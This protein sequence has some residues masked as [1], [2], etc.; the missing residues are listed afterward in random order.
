M[1]PLRIL[2]SGGG[3]AGPA[4]AFW[5]ARL[6][7]ACTVLERFPQL[8]ASGQ[9]I[10]IREQG[11]DTARRMGLLETIRSHA[12]DEEGLQFVDDRGW[13][14]ALFPRTEAG[15]GNQG[16]SSEFEIMRGDL[17]RVLAGAAPAANKPDYRFG[18]SVDGFDNE[19]G[20]VRVKLSDGSVERYDMLVGADGQGSRIRKMMLK[21]GDGGKDLSR[22]LG[23]YVAYYSLPRTPQDPSLGT[24]YHA[25]GRRLLATRWH[26]PQRGQGYL[27]TMAHGE[28]MERALKQDVGTQKDVFARVFGDAGWQAAR[29]V[30]EM[31]RADDFYAQTIVQIKCRPW[32]RGRVVLLGDAGYCPSPLTGMGTSAALIGAYV[33]AGELSKRGISSSSPSGQGQE[34]AVASALAAYEEVLRPFVEEIQQ[35]PR[36]LPRLVY[37]ETAVGVWILRSVLGLMSTLKLNRLFESSLMQRNGWKLPD[38]PQLRGSE[39]QTRR[40]LTE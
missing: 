28:E 13:R 26:S 7:H 19:R 25:T 12:V 40:L 38:Y 1:A 39:P 4:L 17:C 2:I 32:S 6:G 35:L 9:Q 15:S 10:D 29:L 27:A 8:R 36:G 14:R 33:L 3:I 23:V 22:S 31:R 20:G 24:M 11:V 5:M 30:D 16:F 34:D 37:P 18:L 21:D